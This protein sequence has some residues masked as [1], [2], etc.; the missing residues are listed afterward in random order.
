MPPIAGLRLS[1]SLTSFT[2]P[3]TDR[4]T[5]FLLSP[6]MPP[7]LAMVINILFIC[8]LGRIFIV[9]HYDDDRINSFFPWLVSRHD[10]PHHCPGNNYI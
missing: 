1:L 5:S 7:F 9:C 4:Q 10:H 2:D 6:S 3:E 8:D